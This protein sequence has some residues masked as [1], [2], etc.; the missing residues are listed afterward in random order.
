ME[1]LAEE[2]GARHMSPWRIGAWVAAAL[3]L[4]VIF[5]VMQVTDEVNWKVG[6]FI[7]A[8][9]LLFGSLGAYEFA[10]RTS[11]NSAYRAGIGVAI[12]AALLLVW[13]NGAVGIT[14]SDADGFYLVVVAIGII[15][16]VFARLRPDGMARAMIVTA[17]AHALVGPIALIAGIVPAHNSVLEILGLTAFF[18]ALFIGSAVNFREAARDKAKRDDA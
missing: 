2:G 15:G 17:V 18:A 1:G 3:L 10:I 12:G 14:D 6:D 7:V 9:V 8:G 11:G 13:V 4:L 5:V 16:A